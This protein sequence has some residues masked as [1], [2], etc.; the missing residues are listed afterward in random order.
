MTHFQAPSVPSDP[1]N[2]TTILGLSVAVT[3][4]ARKFEPQA[5]QYGVPL[6]GDL[7]W[8]GWA[9]A[10]NAGFADRLIVIGGLEHLDRDTCPPDVGWT[11]P[12]QDHV[13][14]VPRGLACC[15]ALASEFGVDRAKLDWRHSE[16]NTGSNAQTI[17][18][19]V[20]E[21]RSPHRIIIS[22]NFYHL[23]RAQ[24]DLHSQGI[25]TIAT[26][27]AEAFWVAEQLARGADRTHVAM[28]MAAAFGGGP[29]ADRAAAEIQGAADKLNNLYQPLSS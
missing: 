22:S 3:A 6:F 25:M 8:K 19:L 1:V 7:R 27:P 2:P 10:L 5:S 16:G 29:L 15:H 18:S 13:Q 9:S 28:D 21:M 26:V 17:R 23:P 12:E 4:T 11:S 24:M 14:L 20:A